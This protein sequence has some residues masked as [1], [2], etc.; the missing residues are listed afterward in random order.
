MSA[1][2]SG[3]SIHLKYVADHDIQEWDNLPEAADIGKKIKRKRLEKFVSH[4]KF[5][6]AYS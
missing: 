2:R 1:T 5:P 6:V 3:R 4:W